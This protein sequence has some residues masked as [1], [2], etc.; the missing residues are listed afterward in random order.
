MISIIEEEVKE[1]KQISEKLYNVRLRIG[2][3]SDHKTN[4]SLDKAA[5]YINEFLRDYR[6]KHRGE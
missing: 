4:P 6:E 3:K 1:L 2:R 5:D